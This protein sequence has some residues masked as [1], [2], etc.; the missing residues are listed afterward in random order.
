VQEE[1]SSFSS[2]QMMA[3]EES[4]GLSRDVSSTPSNDSEIAIQEEEKVKMDF[5]SQSYFDVKRANFEKRLLN[6]INR[7][8]QGQLDPTPGSPVGVFAQVNMVKDSEL[9]ELGLDGV[10]EKV[11]SPRNNASQRNIKLKRPDR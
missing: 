11:T 2:S 10:Y 6:T 5:T 8:S 3:P 7:A 1:D 9:H 4:L